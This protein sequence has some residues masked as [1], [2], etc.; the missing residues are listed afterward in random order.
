MKTQGVGRVHPAV[1]S[2]PPKPLVLAGPM[3]SNKTTVF[4]ELLKAGAYTHFSAQLEPCLT[5]KST[6]HTLNTPCHPLNT[7]YTSPTRTPYPIQ[8]AQVE[9]RGDRV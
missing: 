4:E 5:H 8:G 2:P 6:L 3:G 7:G 9:L 1:V